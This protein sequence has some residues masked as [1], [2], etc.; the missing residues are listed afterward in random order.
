MKVNGKLVFE[1]QENNLDHFLQKAY[2][3]LGG[4]YPKFHKMDRL[5]K[6]GFLASEVILSNSVKESHTSE[7]IA[8]VLSNRESSLDTDVRFQN[9]LETAPSPSLFVYTLPNIVIGEICIRNGI[10]GE[11]AFFVFPEFNPEFLA[12]YTE[13]LFESHGMTAAIGGWVDVERERHDVFLYL[14][15]D[16]GSGEAIPHSM[17]NL[18]K[19]YQGSHG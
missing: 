17:E 16:R 9:T 13:G 1:S 5:C 8:I 4:D 12:N 6:A 10:T 14:V 19:L 11:N 2:E 15:E 18:F 7:N 3:F